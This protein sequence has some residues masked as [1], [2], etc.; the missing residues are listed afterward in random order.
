MELKQRKRIVNDLPRFN[1]GQNGNVL[2]NYSF[3]TSL[4]SGNNYT[5][6]LGLSY[7]PAAQTNMQTG[8]NELTNNNAYNLGDSKA[9]QMNG[10]TA[11]DMMYGSK[12]TDLSQYVQ[13]GGGKGKFDWQSYSADNAS[14]IGDALSPREKFSDNT[15]NNV[16]MYGKTVA[17]TVGGTYGK[18]A[19]EIVDVVADNIGMANYKHTNEE[20]MGD[21]GVSNAN[22]GG[23]TYK[24]Q[25]YTDNKGA[26]HDVDSSAVKNAFASGF[27]G[28]AAGMRLGGGWGAIAGGVLGNVF[29]IF[30]GLKAMRRQRRINA[31]N[32][33]QVAMINQGQKAMADTENL[34]RRYYQRYGNSDGVMVANRGKD[35]RARRIR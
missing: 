7:Q 16:R 11:K 32:D 14:A 18:A 26:R 21:A 13:A 28:S 3:N 29:G 2:N 19:G 5:S 10:Y 22:I 15:S 33:K 31:N 9:A 35:L 23:I 34:Q 20:M 27:K 24:R 1:W 6:S 30:S 4:S 12:N 8:I 17:G 25:N